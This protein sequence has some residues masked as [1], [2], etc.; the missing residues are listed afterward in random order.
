M[1]GRVVWIYFK[2]SKSF[3]NLIHHVALTRRSNDPS[4]IWF[5][6]VINLFILPVRYIPVTW[7]KK[8][9]VKEMIR[10][11]GSKTLRI[12]NFQEVNV[13]KDFQLM[14]TVYPLYGD[15]ILK[16]DSI[17][18]HIKWWRKMN[19]VMEYYL[20]RSWNLIILIIAYLR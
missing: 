19:V 17:M 2:I 10:C 11:W 14:M 13:W 16:S 12:S 1:K 20:K 5:Y 8:C 18:W 6:I 7:L 9:D 3:S 4:I 15:R